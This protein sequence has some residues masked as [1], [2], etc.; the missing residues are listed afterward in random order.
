MSK[1]FLYI[2]LQCGHSWLS[3]YPKNKRPVKCPN[4]KCTNPFYWWRKKEP[5]D[6]DF[7]KGE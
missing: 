6:G 7:L 4:P 5:N 1:R 2:C 3:K